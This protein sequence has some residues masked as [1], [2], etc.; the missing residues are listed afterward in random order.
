MRTKMVELPVQLLVLGGVVSAQTLVPYHETPV[1]LD[2]VVAKELG[3]FKGANADGLALP[4]SAGTLLE[5]SMNRDR[6]AN[7]ATGNAPERCA[8]FCA[9][10]YFKLSAP[11]LRC[12]KIS[13]RAATIPAQAGCLWL[14]ANARACRRHPASTT[15]RQGSTLRHD[16]SMAPRAVPVAATPLKHAAVPTLRAC[17]STAARHP[18]DPADTSAR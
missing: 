17:F 8:E 18:E 13:V 2:C 5:R 3:C 12:R 14:A 10:N 16:A 6:S 7:T 4:F 9:T 1:L 15:S 11:P